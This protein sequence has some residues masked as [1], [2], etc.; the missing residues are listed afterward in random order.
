MTFCKRLLCGNCGGSMWI[1]ALCPQSPC[2][3]THP[4]CMIGACNCHVR[5]S[6]RHSW[7]YMEKWTLAKIIFP[8]LLRLMCLL[9]HMRLKST[10][11]LPR[12]L[13]RPLTMSRG[14]TTSRR[15]WI[16]LQVITQ[17]SFIIVNSLFTLHRSQVGAV[18]PLLSTNKNTLLLVDNS[19]NKA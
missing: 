13:L 4:Q 18:H 17:N 10:Q 1:A 14:E 19:I 12:N 2:W 3:L 7:R 11:S 5:A 15:C 8:Q 16:N 9:F 6:K